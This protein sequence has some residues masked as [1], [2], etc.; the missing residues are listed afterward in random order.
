MRVYI[1]QQRNTEALHRIIIYESTDFVNASAKSFRKRG[2]K[3]PLTF[4]FEMPESEDGR[5]CRGDVL[6]SHLSAIALAAQYI[7]LF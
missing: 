2:E 3:K 6:K 4:S 1:P 5:T 7:L